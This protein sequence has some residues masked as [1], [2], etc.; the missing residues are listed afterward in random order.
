MYNYNLGK[1]K[2]IRY[3]VR[4]RVL[5][6]DIKAAQSIKEKLINWTLK[7]RLSG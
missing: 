5:K 3:K 1:K 4:Q 2:K 6:G 7:V